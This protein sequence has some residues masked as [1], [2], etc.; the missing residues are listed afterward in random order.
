MS[1]RKRSG[2]LGDARS[3]RN[4]HKFDVQYKNH[5]QENLSCVTI[6]LYKSQDH[7]MDYKLPSTI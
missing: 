5:R 1:K 3:V 4:F 2:Y 7:H 6:N